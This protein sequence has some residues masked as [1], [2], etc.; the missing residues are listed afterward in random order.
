MKVYAEY[1][2]EG[3]IEYRRKTLLQFNDSIDLIGSAVLMNPGEAR[4]ITNKFDKCFIKDFYKN[5]H[6]YDL[7]DMDIWYS[8]TC[9]STMKFLE[10]IFSGWYINKVNKENEVIELN[11]IIQL[12]NCFY[13]KNPDL[14]IVREQFSEESKYLFNESYFFSNKPVYFGW[15]KEEI[16]KYIA[17]YIFTNYNHKNTPIYNHNF[18]ENE[19]YHPITVNIRYKDKEVYD[20][21]KKFHKEVIK[22]LQ[23]P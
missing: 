20:F 3:N 2:K 9:D 18:D 7:E 4:P 15:G 17:E 19:F 5:T 21:L 11:G 6:N 8:F 23:K 14:T 13:Y 12:F 1:I 22:S 10:K 16:F